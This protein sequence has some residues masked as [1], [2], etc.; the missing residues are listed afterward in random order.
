MDTVA[1][2]IIKNVKRQSTVDIATLC[3]GWTLVIDGSEINYNSL[4][5]FCLVG[6]NRTIFYKCIECNYESKT[7]DF[8]KNLFVSVLNEIGPEYVNF[9]ITDGAAN[10]LNAATA[11][12]DVFPAITGMRCSIH[13][14]NLFLKDICSPT[15]NYVVPSIRSIVEKANKVVDFVV[16]KPFIRKLL[17][18]STQKKLKRICLT[19]FYTQFIVIERVHELYQNVNNTLTNED[20]ITWLAKPQQARIREVSA[21][22]KLIVA[23][24]DFW[25]Q[26]KLL[27]DFLRPIIDLMLK[28]D[29]LTPIMG[30]LY[31]YLE[32]EDLRLSTAQL[33]ILE[34]GEIDSIRSRFQVRKNQL[35]HPCVKAAFC[36]DP[37]NRNIVRLSRY[38]DCR[39]A[40]FGLIEQRFGERKKPDVLQQWNEYLVGTG[41]FEHEAI[42]LN[43]RKQSAHNWWYA[44]GGDQ[45]LSQ[46]AVKLL[47]SVASNSEAE[48][49]WSDF[50]VVCTKERSRLTSEKASDFVMI[51]HNLKRGKIMSRKFFD[52]IDEEVLGPELDNLEVTDDEEVQPVVEEILVPE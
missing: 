12:Q 14:L 47:S 40:L 45:E 21:E 4:I 31:R 8:L 44:N 37:E 5:N 30:K 39:N 29:S 15:S 18:K 10:Y 43:A 22:V 3:T 13:T 24:D 23:D 32:L 52:W 7:V 35:A 51:K 33:S 34:P 36:L 27:I 16:N 38:L 9:V 50:S 25:V 48:R 19:R 1:P 46:L 28:M 49:N 42:F 41:E 17:K 11:V 6:P 20:Y 26:V 2:K